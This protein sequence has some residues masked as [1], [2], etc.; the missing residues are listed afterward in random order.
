MPCQVLGG[1]LGGVFVPNLLAIACEPTAPYGLMRYTSCSPAQIPWNIPQRFW[2]RY[3]PTEL[4]SLPKH[5]VAPHGMPPIAFTY[6]VDGRTYL[7]AFN[8]TAPVPFP[9]GATRPAD[10]MT[11][12][13][14]KGYMAAVSWTDHLIGRL[15]KGLEAR[16]AAEHTI[17]ALLGDRAE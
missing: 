17:V 6:E 14:R 2:D 9:A 8:T 11:R 3:P 10:N 12:T 5:Q 4:I 7:R 16:G 15:L 1:M 13:L